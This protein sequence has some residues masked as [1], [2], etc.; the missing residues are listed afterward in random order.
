MLMRSTIRYLVLSGKKENLDFFFFK[1]KTSTCSKL[2]VI[3]ALIARKIA[4]IQLE[5]VS[6]FYWGR[7]ICFFV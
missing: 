5:V 2:I 4:E 7:P 1:S 3:M 6:T